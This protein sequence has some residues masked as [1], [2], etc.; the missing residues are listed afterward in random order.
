MEQSKS[1][2]L[3]FEQFEETEIKVSKGFRTEA[4]FHCCRTLQQYHQTQ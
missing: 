1:D 2:E 4:L 3:E